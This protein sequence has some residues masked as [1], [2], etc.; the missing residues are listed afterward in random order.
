[1]PTPPSLDPVVAE[2]TVPVTPTE[3]FVGFTAQMGEWWDPQI[4]PDPAT[5]TG[6]AIDPQGD[7]ALVHGDEQYVWGRVREWDPGTRYTQDFWLGHA[8]EDPTTLDVSFT[9]ADG[10]TRVRVKHSGWSEGS[11]AIREN[12]THWS[13]LLERYAAHVS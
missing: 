7:V 6:I 4:T 8:E 10:G 12:Y 11:E 2:I 9:E 3:A 1:M 5:F 13:A